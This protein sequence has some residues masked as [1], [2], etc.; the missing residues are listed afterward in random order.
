VKVGRGDEHLTI[1]HNT[2]YKEIVVTGCG[3]GGGKPTAEVLLRLLACTY[4]SFQNN[5]SRTSKLC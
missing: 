1:E 3:D 5:F 2:D 4:H